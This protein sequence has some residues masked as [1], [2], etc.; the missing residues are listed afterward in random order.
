[1]WRI[2]NNHD[3]CEYFEIQNGQICFHVFDLPECMILSKYADVL[4][5]A[6]DYC[7]NIYQCLY[8]FKF[9]KKITTLLKI[10]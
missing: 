1:M 9:L 10:S 4:S 3:S 8:I 5:I 2:R 7:L 6:L